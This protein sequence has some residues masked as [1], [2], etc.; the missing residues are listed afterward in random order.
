MTKDKVLCLVQL[1]PPIHGAAVMNM[2][3]VN[4]IKEKFHVDTMELSFS[5]NL[6]Q[7]RKISFGKVF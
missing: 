4:A 6:S 3:A 7:V 2:H 1:P 5:K